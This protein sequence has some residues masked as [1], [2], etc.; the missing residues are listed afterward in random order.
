VG[1][2]SCIG[3]QPAGEPSPYVELASTS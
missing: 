1:I 3:E 2:E